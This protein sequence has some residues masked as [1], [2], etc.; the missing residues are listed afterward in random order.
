MIIFLQVELG[1][2]D[3]LQEV[4]GP[5][6]IHFAPIFLSMVRKLCFLNSNT[7]LLF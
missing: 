5:N 4:S 2:F 6:L 7:T 1:D 3:L